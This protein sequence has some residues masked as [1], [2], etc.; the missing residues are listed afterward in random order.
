M[1]YIKGFNQFRKVFSQSKVSVF[2][3]TGVACMFFTFL[4]HDNSME[5]GISG[6]ASIF[7][8][9]GV[10]NFTAIETELKDEQKIQR[11]IKRA[12]KGLVH[13]QEK[14]R[15]IQ[16]MSVTDPAFITTELDEMDNYV[17]LCILYL[18]EV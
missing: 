4:T 3:L 15:K 8:G 2:I 10:N 7:I 5:L 6:I 12:I 18:E 16:K 9:I 1:S 13:I 14:L 17:G 11:K